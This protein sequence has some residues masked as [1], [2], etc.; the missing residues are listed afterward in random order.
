MGNSISSNH[1]I[2]ITFLEDKNR[3]NFL[4]TLG[5]CSKSDQK[6]IKELKSLY[7]SHKDT[8]NF[9]VMSEGELTTPYLWHSENLFVC[10]ITTPNPQ[11]E[12]GYCAYHQY[13]SLPFITI[14]CDRISYNYL[15]YFMNRVRFYLEH[16]EFLRYII[17]CDEKKDEKCLQY[18]FP[19]D[20]GPVH[21]FPD[22]KIIVPYDIQ[23]GQVDLLDSSVYEQTEQSDLVRIQRDFPT[24]LLS[25][26]EPSIP[27]QSLGASSFLPA[28]SEPSTMN[29]PTDT[30]FSSF[31]PGV[32]EPN[33]IAND[34]LN[35]ATSFM[36]AISEP[37]GMSSNSASSFLNQ[38]SEP[39][40]INSS[41]ASTGVSSQFGLVSEP[42]ESN[43][44]QD[45]ASSFFGLVSEPFQNSSQSSFF[46]LV[47]EPGLSSNNYDNE[48]ESKRKKRRHFSGGR[49]SRNS[50]N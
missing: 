6:P 3:E 47:S 12:L 14:H 37:T 45:S 35:S 20:K 32:S 16:E 42:P 31:L 22:M 27:D 17:L 15:I 46:G 9:V 11:I 44:Y 29:L 38:V 30:G 40:G 2:N 4:Q 43:L 36:H 33:S 39:S 26:S 34:D 8:K 49:K 48:S 25:L 21:E 18:V 5:Q 23:A 50:G 28:I 7:S 41:S 24:Q 10:A 1:C 19:P 13:H